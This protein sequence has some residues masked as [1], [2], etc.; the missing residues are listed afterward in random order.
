VGCQHSQ[1][2]MVDLLR[3]LFMENLG[4][5]LILTTVT[6][7]LISLL[8]SSRSARLTHLTGTKSLKLVS[9]VLKRSKQKFMNQKSEIR[10][11][12]V[13]LFL[14]S[15]S[16]GTHGRFTPRGFSHSL[17]FMVSGSMFL[18]SIAVRVAAILRCS[19]LSSTANWYVYL[20]CYILCMEH[21]AMSFNLLM[22]MF[23]L[24]FYYLRLSLCPLL[25][26]KKLRMKKWRNRL[27]LSHLEFVVLE[28]HK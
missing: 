9:N 21:Y 25:L 15:S 22:F 28:F 20:V 24:F 5:T 17:V 3:S 10:N 1:H 4:S 2:A 14:C 8:T 6:V 23:S 12:K 27:F 16:T 19:M 18:T 7:L 26:S 13:N 11:Q